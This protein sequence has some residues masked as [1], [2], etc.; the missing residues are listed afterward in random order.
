MIY[1]A[2]YLLCKFYLLVI[3]T[4]FDADSAVPAMIGILLVSVIAMIISMRKLGS[5]IEGFFSR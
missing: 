3:S 1:P 4:I 2:T 5:A